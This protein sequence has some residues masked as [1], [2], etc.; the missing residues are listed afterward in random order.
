MGGKSV[1]ENQLWNVIAGRSLAGGNW[2]KIVDRKQL[3][4]STL[5]KILNETEFVE[6]TWRI[7]IDGRSF[8]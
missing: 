2:C 8:V 3:A 7:I 4:R 5:W 1:V 6:H